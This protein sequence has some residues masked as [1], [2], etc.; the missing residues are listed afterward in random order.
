[1]VSGGTI[2][3]GVGKYLDRRG[4]LQ[5]ARGWNG[6]ATCNR[7]CAHRPGGHSPVLTVELLS[8]HSTGFVGA[9]GMILSE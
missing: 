9:T 6:T 2:P 3:D 8:A 7:A 1:M 5:A 4:D